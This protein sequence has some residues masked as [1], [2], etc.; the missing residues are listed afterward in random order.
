MKLEKRKKII[1]V[2]EAY[3]LK[4][5]DLGK[6]ILYPLGSDRMYLQHEDIDN[7]EGK[8]GQSTLRAWY[9][10]KPLE[11]HYKVYFDEP[12]RIEVFFDSIRNQTI[13]LD[14]TESQYGTNV[15]MLCLCGKR[16]RILYLYRDYF[17]CRDCLHLKYELTTINHHT[18]AGNLRRMM[19]RSLKLKEKQLHLGRI[20]YKGKIT[21]KTKSF[22]NLVEKNSI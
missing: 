5:T 18:L 2:E 12:L 8:A 4:T 11:L 3:K 10:N 22:I 21:K 20:D 1:T 6:L 13:L 7:L 17:A 15:Y 19:H 9:N 14:T 16:C